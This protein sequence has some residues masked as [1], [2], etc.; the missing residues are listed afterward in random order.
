MGGFILEMQFFGV[1]S[2]KQLIWT[3]ENKGNHHTHQEGLEQ[4]CQSGNSLNDGSAVNQNQKSGC[5][6][7]QPCQA[8]LI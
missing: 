5:S 1:Q 6:C 2:G 7:E 8:V 4:L 3:A